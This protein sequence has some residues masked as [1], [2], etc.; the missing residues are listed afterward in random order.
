[1][2]RLAAS[3]ALFDFWPGI[4]ETFVSLRGYLCVQVFEGCRTARSCLGVTVQ[5][6]ETWWMVKEPHLVNGN[7]RGV[8]IPAGRADVG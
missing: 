5:E 4:R 6:S 8:M 1:M 7:C 3:R 2:K